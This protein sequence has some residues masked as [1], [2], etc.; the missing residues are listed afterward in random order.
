[1]H[2]RNVD[3][4]DINQDIRVAFV[5]SILAFITIIAFMITGFASDIATG[6]VLLRNY[7][8]AIGAISIVFTRTANRNGLDRRNAMALLLAFRLGIANLSLSILF[9]IIF[10]FML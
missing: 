3:M 10:A 4:K 1:M 8:I 9:F 7:G 6:L 5:F 2:W